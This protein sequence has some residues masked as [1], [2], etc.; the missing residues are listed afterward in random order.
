MV[1]ITQPNV[2]LENWSKLQLNEN[3]W[4]SSKFLYLQEVYIQKMISINKFRLDPV[5]ALFLSF[6]YVKK[7]NM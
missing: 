7:Q 3:M 1:V 4:K 2:I 6:K 5:G